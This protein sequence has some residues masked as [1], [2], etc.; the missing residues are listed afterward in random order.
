MTNNDTLELAMPELDWGFEKIEDMAERLVQLEQ[1]GKKVVPIRYKGGVA[2]L[3]LGHQ[4]ISEVFRDEAQLPAT[5]FFRQQMD[6]MGTSLFHLDGA[7]HKA[8]KTKILSQLSPSVVRRLTEELLV[9]VADQLIDEF[10]EA[11]EI[12]FLSAYGR[13][14][15]FNIISKLLGVSVPRDQEAAVMKMVGDLT[16]IK[17]P[18]TPPEEMR[19]RALQAVADTNLLLRPVVDA[20]KADPKNDLISYFIGL[21]VDGRRL[22]DNDVM[23]FA[24]SFYQAGADSTGLQMGNLINA[25]LSRPDLTKTMVNHPEKRM[26]VIDELM[27]LE[28]VVGLVSRLTTRETTIAGTVIPADS[29]VLLGVPGANRDESQFPDADQFSLDRKARNIMTFGAGVRLCPGNHLARQEIKISFDRLF[30]R[31]PELRLVNP[32]ARQGGTLFRF[33]A[34]GVPIRFDDILPAD[35]VPMSA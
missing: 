20:R 11:R 15:A 19:Q 13:R 7:E 1:E 17:E 16:Q 18:N 4:L 9:P 12:E 10:G 33:I 23:D 26:A 31:L 25:I 2:W 35:S 6:T 28:P 32:P 3:V 21:E 5:P 27:R 14:Y 8:Y 29:I 24:R 22:S 30:D 34:E